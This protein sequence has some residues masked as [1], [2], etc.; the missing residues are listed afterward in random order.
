MKAIKYYSIFSP[1]KKKTIAYEETVGILVVGTRAGLE[2]FLEL[3]IL[4]VHFLQSLLTF[5]D[6]AS[7]RTDS[8]KGLESWNF[9]F[10][11][12]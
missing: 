3:N 8:I 11:A 12:W 5:S 6:K 1:T 10:L 2:D 9:F 4:V 7:I